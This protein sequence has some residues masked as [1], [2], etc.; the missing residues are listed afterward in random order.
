MENQILKEQNVINTLI[1]ILV[2]ILCNNTYSQINK[3]DKFCIDYPMKEFSKCLLFE[4]KNVF[5]YEYSGDTGVFEYGKGEYKFVKNFLILNYNKTEPQ[6][7][8]YHLSKIWLNKLDHIKINFHFFDFNNIPLPYVNIIYQDTL[9]KNGFS[10]VAANEKGLAVV[11]LKRDRTKI[12]FKISNL[13]FNQY[14]LTIDKNYNYDISVFLQK[15]GHGL[16]ILDQI[17]TLEIV[18]N[19]PKYFTV[20][21]KNGSISTWK[22][23]DD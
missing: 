20:K 4:T 8:G 16:P 22:K 13:A 1:F 21:N 12:Q 2:G 10:G 14:E 7:K 9:S 18:K 6:K 3:Q 19:K 17:D 23:S 15:E 11:N 5:K